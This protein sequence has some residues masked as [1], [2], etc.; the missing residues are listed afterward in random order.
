MTG[1]LAVMQGIRGLRSALGRAPVALRL[2]RYGPIDSPKVLFS[3]ATFLPDDSESPFRLNW[4]PCRCRPST[5]DTCGYCYSA[6]L[7]L[8][9]AVILSCWIGNVLD[10]EMA[11]NRVE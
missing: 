5:V 10:P 9:G 8:T 1:A 2:R 11:M 7:A 6:R 4:E 3:S